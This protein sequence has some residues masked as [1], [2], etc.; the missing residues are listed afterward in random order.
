MRAIKTIGYISTILLISFG[1]M[2]FSESEA[3]PQENS[4]SA[5][6]NGQEDHHI[7]LQDALHLISNFRKDNP[8]EKP[9]GGFFGRDAIL[10]ILSQEE[11][12]GIRYYYA[13]D[14][15]D[16]P[17]LILVGVNAQGED[18]LDGKLAE[19][20]FLCPPFCAPDALIH[21]MAG[22]EKIAER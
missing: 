22:Q 13:K 12:V 16:T 15:E 14:D 10:N 8:S 9:V 2:A 17:M 7:T 3:S 18:M 5:M 20:S 6:F 11:A 21:N 4:E 1:L 19:R